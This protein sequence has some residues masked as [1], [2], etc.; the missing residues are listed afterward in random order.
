MQL[1]ENYDVFYDSSQN[2]YKP[3]LLRQMT[4]VNS[5]KQ[6]APQG[7]PALVGDLPLV[8]DQA[9]V[10]NIPPAI[11]IYHNSNKRQEIANY[12]QTPTNNSTY[13]ATVSSKRQKKKNYIQAP[14]DISTHN[15]TNSRNKKSNNTTSARSRQSV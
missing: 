2:T 7:Y 11:S 15:A 12:I 4:N 3:S 9:S 6:Y 5:L 1:N 10:E 13:N 14:I 8:V